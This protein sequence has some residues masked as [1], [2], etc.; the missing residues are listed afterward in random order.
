MARIEKASQ[1]S[2]HVHDGQTTTGKALLQELAATLLARGVPGSG[3]VMVDIIGG[4]FVTG[5]TPEEAR[6]RFEA[7]H[8]GAEGWMQRFSDVVGGPKEVGEHAEL[9]IGRVS[10]EQ[11]GGKAR[12][13]TSMR[14]RRFARPDNNFSRTR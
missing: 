5:K 13:S 4:E 10:A 12:S 6:H 8:P 11:L 14:N 1:S 2:E 3:Y 7:L 9:Q